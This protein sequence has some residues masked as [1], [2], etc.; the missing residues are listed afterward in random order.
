MSFWDSSAIIPLCISEPSSPEIKLLAQ[1]S[2]GMVVWWGAIVEV[3]SAIERKCRMGELSMDGKANAEVRLSHLA[4]VWFDIP[5][6]EAVRL[7]A[8]RLLVKHPLRAADALQLSA[9]LEWAED[10][11]AGRQ[12]I[13][14]D[15]RLRAAANLE[16]FQVLP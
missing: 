7:R 14:L 12:F 8:R 11:P 1:R 6:L 2:E 9:A 16:G 10:S 13:C 5:P 4:F 15:S 3:Q